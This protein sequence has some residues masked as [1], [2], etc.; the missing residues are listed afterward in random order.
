MALIVVNIYAAEFLKW[1]DPPSIFRTSFQS[2]NFFELLIYQLWG[3]QN[4]N[5]KFESQ[6]STE[7]LQTA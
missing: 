6:Q 4:E 1:T 2:I 5:L 3:Y 7:P